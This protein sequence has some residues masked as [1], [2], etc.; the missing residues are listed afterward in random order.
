MAVAKVLGD[1]IGQYEACNLTAGASAP[2][3]LTV[4]RPVCGYLGLP[5]VP[6]LDYHIR[7]NRLPVCRSCGGLRRFDKR[8]LDAWIRGTNSLTLARERRRK[9]R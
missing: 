7:N 4:D 8:E 3:P 5:S 6:A 9:S 2:D 1:S